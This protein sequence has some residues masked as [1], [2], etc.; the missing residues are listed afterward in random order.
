MGEPCTEGRG[1]KGQGR[2]HTALQLAAVIYGA[3]FVLSS[4][5]G[6]C[7]ASRGSRGVAGEGTE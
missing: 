6:R 5:P 7:P 4:S 2:I 3:S 1:T